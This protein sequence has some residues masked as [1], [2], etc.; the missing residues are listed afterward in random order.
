M[1]AIELE[2]LSKHFKNTIAVKRVNFN[3]SEGEFFGLL[4]PNGAGKTTLINM[5]AGLA[6]PTAGTARVFG[7]DIVEDYRKVHS[8]IGLAPGEVNFD[9]EFNVFE[10]LVHH[11]G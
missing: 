4:G 9:R 7:M 2:N 6:S 8:Q 10:N 3:I 5:L 1:N 11:G